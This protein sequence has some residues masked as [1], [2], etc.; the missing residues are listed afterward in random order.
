VIYEM[1]V[2][3]FTRH[4]SSGVKFPGT[5]AGLRAKIP[6]LKELGVNC[7]ELM[8]IYE[9]DEFEAAALIRDRGTTLQLLGI[10]YGRF[11]APKP[12]RCH[13]QAQHAGGR[14]EGA[15]ERVASQRIEVFLDVVFNHTAEGN[16]NGPTS[17]SG[18]CDNR[19]TTC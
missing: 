15:G 6:Y 8:P 1:H 12:L 2:R 16:E 17:P 10:Q 5:F 9:F 13:R 19:R 3:S 7:V 14:V 4:P 11:F 18:A